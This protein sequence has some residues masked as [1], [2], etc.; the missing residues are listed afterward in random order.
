M[1]GSSAA[2]DVEGRR[3]HPGM[4]TGCRRGKADA[5]LDGRISVTSDGEVH[6]S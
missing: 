3:R 6:A 1:H 4:R 5:S 2:V